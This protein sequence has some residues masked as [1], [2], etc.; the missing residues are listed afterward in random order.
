[1]REEIAT[2]VSGAQSVPYRINPKENT[3]RH[4]LIKVTKIKQ[5]EKKNIKVGKGK[6]PYNIYRYPQKLTADLSAETLQARREWQDI[7]IKKKKK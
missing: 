3:P 5:K 1:M 6:A 2:Q 7:Y 4:I